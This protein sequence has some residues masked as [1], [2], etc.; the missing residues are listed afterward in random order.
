MLPSA[1]H[2]LVLHT[3]K[4]HSFLVTQAL[5]WSIQFEFEFAC[6]RTAAK[7]G[8][9]GTLRD[10]SCLKLIE[11][12]RGMIKL[13]GKCVPHAMMRPCMRAVIRTMRYRIV[14]TKRYRMWM[15]AIVGTGSVGISG[16]RYELMYGSA[17][18]ARRES[19]QGSA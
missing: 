9:W 8:F 14:R 17:Q 18:D 16:L 3:V 7:E 19:G 1:N 2:W 5:V 15:V 4:L 10:R 13:L 11:R 6:C 12:K